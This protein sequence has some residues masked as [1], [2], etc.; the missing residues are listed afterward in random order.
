MSVAL[1]PDAEKIISG[2]LRTHADVVALSARVVGAT[3]SN[4]GMA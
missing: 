2:Y 3:P 4:T 1:S